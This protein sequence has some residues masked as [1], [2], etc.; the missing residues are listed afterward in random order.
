MQMST[1]ADLVKDEALVAEGFERVK[2][3]LAAVP[4]DQLS[5]VNVDV[6]SATR[7]ILGALPEI[8][9][10]RERIVKELP[11]FDIA[12]FD[13]LEDYVQA[14]KFAQSG[15]QIASEPADELVELTEAGNGLRERLLADAKALAL[16][17]LFDGS[18]LDK[19]KGGNGFNNLAE[20]LELLSR[21][22]LANWQKI[23]G[24]ALTPLEDVQAASRIGLRLTRLAGLREQGPARL[25][26]A[27]ELRQRAFFLLARTYEEARDAIRFLRRR[28][29]D[30]EDIAPNLYSG[31]GR[32][33][34]EEEPDTTGTTATGAVTSSDPTARPGAIG[35]HAAPLP[36]ALPLP[37]SGGASKDPFLPS[38][39]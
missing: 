19:L 30:L 34:P 17:K 38:G 33:K 35:S 9:G 23:Q 24:K 1:I 32:R 11:Q 10:L 39:Q 27:V 15:Y 16:Y 14:L 28:E 20:D 12:S 29:A 2:A 8:K 3:D 6:Q 37:Q 25:A 7:T 26:A 22:M 13:K 36:G 4:A 31:K 18:Q 5:K 21:A